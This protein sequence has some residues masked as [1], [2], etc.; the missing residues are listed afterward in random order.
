VQPIKK[1]HQR[2]LSNT[3]MAPSFNL[4]CGGHLLLTD[5]RHFFIIF[6]GNAARLSKDATLRQMA[7]KLKKYKSSDAVITE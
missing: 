1:P 7:M 5:K 3:D 6:L 2:N 4:H